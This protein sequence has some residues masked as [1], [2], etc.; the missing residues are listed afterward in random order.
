MPQEIL[1]FWFSEEARKLWF[2]ST[3]EFDA[4]LRKLVG[5]PKYRPLSM[6]GSV[7]DG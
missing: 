3:P 1:D 4:L 2:K 5:K 6:P 7:T